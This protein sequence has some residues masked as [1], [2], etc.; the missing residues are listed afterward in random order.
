MKKQILGKISKHGDRYI[1]QL[2]VHGGRSAL[3]AA[4]K[5]NKATGL[6]AKEDEHSRWMRQLCDRV[7]M[8]KA[9]VAIANK[10]ARMIVALLK[11]ETTFQ[12]ELAH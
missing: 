4:M 9:S 11:N 12:P 6:F 3:K 10:N 1:R 7:G 5:K 8:N 2:L